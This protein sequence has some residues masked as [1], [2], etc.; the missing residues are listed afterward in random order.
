MMSACLESSSKI[1]NSTRSS[2]NSSISKGVDHTTLTLSIIGKQR[3]AEPHA[4]WGVDYVQ[5]DN[6]R[7]PF[8]LDPVAF[9]NG[10]ARIIGRDTSSPFFELDSLGIFAQGKWEA[11]TQPNQN[12]GVKLVSGE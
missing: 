10:Q 11:S 5:E 12:C 8:T 7:L 9:D 6:E 2:S 4:I 1:P 3:H